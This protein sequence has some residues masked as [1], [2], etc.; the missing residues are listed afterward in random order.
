VRDRK[1]RGNIS[2]DLVFDRQFF[3]FLC[4]FCRGFNKNWDFGNNKEALEIGIK[5]LFCQCLLF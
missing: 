5:V 4:Y 3:F 2:L 1:R